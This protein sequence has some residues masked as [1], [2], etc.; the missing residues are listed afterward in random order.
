LTTRGYCSLCEQREP[1]KLSDS[2]RY[3]L[4][5]ASLR[6]M[7]GAFSVRRIRRILPQCADTGKPHPNTG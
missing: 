6:S 3:A 5:S 4:G 1:E 7:G 2:I